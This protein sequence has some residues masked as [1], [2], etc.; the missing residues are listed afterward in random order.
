ML[1]SMRARLPRGAWVVMVSCLL[2]AVAPTVADSQGF[3][4]EHRWDGHISCSARA[5]APAFSTS[6]CAFWDVAQLLGEHEHQNVTHAGLG[7]KTI[8]VA[9]VWEPSERSL[10]PYLQHVIFTNIEE[11]TGMDYA[12]IDPAAL[13]GLEYRLDA[14]PGD[15]VLDW[16]GATEP[17]PIE[18]RITAG[19]A[20]EPNVV[21]QQ[22]F[23]VH[24]H[25]FY[26]EHAPVGYSAL[27]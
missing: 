2:F 10:H 5:E 7:L 16:D 21:L 15:P 12:F 23:T 22:P 17:I 19:S 26:G 27:P 8:V 6:N 14:D 11:P 18:F 24:Y 20:G 9:M 1:W 4:T 25:L 13:P 3:S